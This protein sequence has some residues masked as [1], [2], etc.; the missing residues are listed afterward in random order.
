[1]DRKT[2]VGVS[3]VFFLAML[4]VNF[5]GNSK[6]L[7]NSVSEVSAKYTNFLTPAG[8]TFSI[9]GIIYLGI[10]FYCLYLLKATEASAPSPEEGLEEK[11]IETVYEVGWLFPFTCLANAAWIILWTQEYLGLSFLV[12]LFLLS[13]LLRLLSLLQHRH[14]YGSRLL[15]ICVWWPFSLYGGWVLFAAAANLGSWLTALGWETFT[16]D[17]NWSFVVLII[18]ACL[19]TL[20]L[21]QR[22]LRVFTMSGIWALL[23]LSAASL[24]SHSRFAYWLLVLAILLFA[25]VLL[26]LIYVKPKAMLLEEGEE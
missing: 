12:I 6:V 11:A 1:M 13:L 9:W 26:H 7:G 2:L 22:N 8:F 21:W 14:Q 17:L 20:A 15:K 19:Y 23:G 5:L 25:N 4:L 3:W 16:A 10:L 24:E 18:L